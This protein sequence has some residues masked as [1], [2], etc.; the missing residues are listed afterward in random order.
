MSYYRCP[1]TMNETRS[2]ASVEDREFIRGA[3]SLRSLPNA[4]DDI[5]ASR[6]RCWKAQRRSRKA[7]GRM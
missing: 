4:W 3:R 2:A 5:P 6:E 1:Q 7:W